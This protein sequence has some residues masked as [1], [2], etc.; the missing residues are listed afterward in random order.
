MTRAIAPERRGDVASVTTASRRAFLKG[1][2]AIAATGLTQVGT[3]R[4]NPLILPFTY[5]A[6]QGALDDLKQRLARVRWPER[7]TVAD[8]SQGVP[9]AKLQ[10]LVEYWRTDYDWRRCEARSIALRSTARRSMAS[11]S[12]SCMF[13]RRMPM[14]CRS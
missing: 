12:T 4:A 2:A 11:T 1:A 5:S 7:E 13:V 6:P 3:A 9:L 8:W 10:A 14:R